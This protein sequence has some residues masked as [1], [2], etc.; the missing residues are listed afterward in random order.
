MEE[1]KTPFKCETSS[2]GIV[3]A[4]SSLSRRI[5]SYFLFIKRFSVCKTSCQQTEENIAICSILSVSYFP[6][7]Q[8]YISAHLGF[9]KLQL[10]ASFISLLYWKLQLLSGNLNPIVC[11]SLQFLGNS[12]FLFSMVEGW[13]INF[14]FVGHKNE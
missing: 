9:C 6:R 7:F 13:G 2:Y 4:Q 1:Q 3:R 8:H 5:I 12:L 10:L 11:F 14:S